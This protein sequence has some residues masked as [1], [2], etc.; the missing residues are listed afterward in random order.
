MHILWRGPL[1]VLSNRQGEYTILNLIT[2]KNV[3]YHMSQ[4]K[5]FL[6]NSMHTD[7]TDVARRDYLEFFIEE[8]VDMRGNISSYGSVCIELNKKVFNCDM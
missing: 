1:R 3:K 4:L 2:L 8:I 7:P 5:T 6:F